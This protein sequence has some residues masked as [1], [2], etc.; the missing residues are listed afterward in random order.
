MSS[1]IKILEKCKNQVLDWIL[2]IFL[3]FFIA[4]SSYNHWKDND[5]LP[6]VTQMQP[7]EDF[8]YDSKKGIWFAEIEGVK[9][10]NCIFIPSQT[11]GMSKTN[12]EWQQVE[13]FFTNDPSPGDSRPTG[14]QHFNT[15]N[16]VT[17][18]TAEEL[19][20]LVKHVC[21][22]NDNDVVVISTI[23]PFKL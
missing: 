6:V 12:G 7:I 18:L 9:Q 23:G 20:V 11:L 22:V 21:R 16:W 3:L 19:K 14:F 10:R 13:F 5:Q 1:L 17:T 2:L 4:T 15:W 8:E